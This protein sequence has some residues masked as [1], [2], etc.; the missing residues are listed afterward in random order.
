MLIIG[1]VMGVTASSCYLVPELGVYFS[2]LRPMHVSGI[3]FW[4]LPAASGCVYY[5]LEM[6]FGVKPSRLLSIAHGTLW[7]IAIVGIYASYLC[8]DFGG[9][10]YWEFNPVWAFPIALGWLMFLIHLIKSIARIPKWPVYIWMWLTGG[11]FFLFSFAESY[12]WLFPYFRE[13]IVTDITIQ[14]KS[15]GSLVGAWNQLIYGTAFF[16]MSRINDG[17][18]DQRSPLAFGMYFLGLFNL[19]FNWGHHIY[20]LPTAPYIRYTGYMVSMTEWV[21]FIKIIYH[22]KRNVAEAQR[23]FH[24]LPY[25][26]L[27]ASDIWVFL[28]LGQAILMSIPALNLYTHGTHITVAHAMGTTIGIN[29][30]ILLAACF[31][32]WGASIKPNKWLA[33]AFWATQAALLAFWVSLNLAGLIKGMWQMSHPQTTFT[34]MMNSLR[35]FFMIFITSGIALASLLLYWAGKLLSLKKKRI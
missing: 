34:D 31:E 3:I 26:F 25:R 21:F 11:L 23:N 5:G 1:L 28:N 17:G 6:G 8:G 29:T 7:V 30:M 35:P 20:T 4:I 24:Y 27:I 9:R 22:W 2:K 14:W 16:L 32:F 10:E 19:M 18:F 15:N 12:L 13:H 33:V